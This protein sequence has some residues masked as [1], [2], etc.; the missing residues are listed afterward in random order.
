MLITIGLRLELRLPFLAG[1]KITEGSSN[2]KDFMLII[3]AYLAERQ[4]SNNLNLNCQRPFSFST[5]SS[6]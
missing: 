3:S 2:L 5:P 6:S 1:V 4:L